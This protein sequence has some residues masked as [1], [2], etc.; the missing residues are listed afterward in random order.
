LLRKNADARARHPVRP[1]ATRFE[2]RGMKLFGILLGLA[3]TIG[4]CFALRDVDQTRT[5]Q[6]LALTAMRRDTPDYNRA[7]LLYQQALEADPANPYR[8]S[9]LAEAFA[10]GGQLDSARL[11]YRQSLELSG[12]VPQCWLRAANFHFNLNEYNEALPLAVRVL[13][14]VPDYDSVLFDYFDQLLPTADLIYGYIGTDRRIV[15]AYAAHLI[16]KGNL[17]AARIAFRFANGAGFLDNNLTASYIDAVVSAHRA[18]EAQRDWLTALGKS[19]GDYPDRNLI[20]NSS[21]ERDLSGISFDWKLT[22]SEA[23]DTVVDQSVA[24]GGHSSLR[25]TFHGDANVSYNNLEQLAVVPPGSYVFQAW[26]RTQ[27]ITTNEGPRIVV[28]ELEPPASVLLH[29]DSLT[30]SSE[31]TLFS[32]QFTVP[33]SQVLSIRIVRQPSQKFDNKVAGS[34]WLDDVRIVHD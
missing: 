17:P 15:R 28:A 26:I 7:I 32:Q 23:F 27:G 12:S 14:A 2:G 13:E 30:G 5:P 4:A 20:Y 9:D 24:H 21:F 33:D 34:F 18:S 3:V 29:T 10:G 6:A 22:P 25:I 19:R 8:W 11:C 1:D 16:Q 31:W